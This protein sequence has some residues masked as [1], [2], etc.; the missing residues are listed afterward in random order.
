MT[1][2]IHNAIVIACVITFFCSILVIL[3]VAYPYFNNELHSEIL[4]EADYLCAGAELGGRDYLEKFQ[5]ERRITLIDTDG[6]VIYDT[7]SDLHE[8]ENHLDREEVKKALES[9]EGES[10][11][12]SAT[13]MEKTYYYARRLDNGTVLRISDD[14]ITLGAVVLRMLIPLLAAFV[15][16]LVLSAAL[17][18][19]LAKSIVKPLNEM[20]F[21][22]PLAGEDYAEISPLVHKLSR[23]NNLIKLQMNDLKKRQKEFQTVTKNM[24]EGLI[25]VD[26]EGDILSYNK[27]ALKLFGVLN[28]DLSDSVLSFNKSEEFEKAVRSALAGEKARPVFDVNGKVLQMYA[29]P[30]RTEEESVSGAV[31]LVLDVTEKEQLDSMRREFTS[32][33]SHELKTPLTSIYG[34]SEMMMSGL[35]KPE[36][37]GK[38]SENI[39]SETGRLITLVNDIMKL[40]RLDENDTGMEMEPIDLYACAREVIDRLT[41]VCEKNGIAMTLSGESV[42]VTGFP[43]VISEMIYNLC[44]NAVKYN[45]ENGTVAVEVGYK[46]GTPYFSVRDTGIGIPKEHLERVFERFYR[47]DKSHSRKIGG[48]GLGLSIVKHGAAVHSAKIKLESREGEGTCVTVTFEEENAE[49]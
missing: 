49:K 4:N 1:K 8:L 22:N 19:S 6:S 20:D 10:W 36:D 5:E 48:T 43:S 34:I 2:K 3:G 12:Y 32:N 30:V 39:H 47:V 26:Y 44:D 9:G 31:L 29:N 42:C 25:L 11:R 28:K 33:V 13:L 14:Q 38:F 17:S 35:V 37:I 45:K 41:I 7:V 23:Q 24:S 27:S 46:K 15:A 18:A 40:S 16:V 21:D